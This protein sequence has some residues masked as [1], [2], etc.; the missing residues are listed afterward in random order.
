MEDNHARKGRVTRNGHM[1]YGVWRMVRM[2]VLCPNINIT[3][4]PTPYAGLIIICTRTLHRKCFPS[5]EIFLD[6]IETPYVPRTL[7][8]FLEQCRCTSVC[9]EV[10]ENRERNRPLRLL[11]SSVSE[12]LSVESLIYGKL[13]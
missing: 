10:L 2:Y 7:V 11:P 1:A 8:G 5:L 12:L 9:E 6:I 13:R 3:Y 4:L